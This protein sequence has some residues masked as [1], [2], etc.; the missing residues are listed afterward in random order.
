MVAIFRPTRSSLLLR[1]PGWTDN[2]LNFFNWLAK[3]RVW[4][5][6][7]V[8]FLVGLR[9]YQHRGI[10]SRLVII[11]CT[12]NRTRHNAS[13]SSSNPRLLSEGERLPRHKNWW[14]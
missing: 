6:Q 12:L 11:K 13:C 14:V 4:S 9:T 5:L 10:C 7:L 8:S 1:G 3:V 2:L